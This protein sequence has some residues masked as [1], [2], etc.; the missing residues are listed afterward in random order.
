ML[1][2]GVERSSIIR[3]VFDR[4]TCLPQTIAPFS[5]GHGGKI[6]QVEK[7][8][9]FLVRVSKWIDGCKHFGP[10][11]ICRGKGW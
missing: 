10:G 2:G 9:P 7:I 5:S 3:N 1:G 11:R 8:I 4:L 6:V